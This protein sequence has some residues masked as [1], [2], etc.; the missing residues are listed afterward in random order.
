LSMI[1]SPSAFPLPMP[2]RYSTAANESERQDQSAKRT[3]FPAGFPASFRKIKPLRHHS[4]AGVNHTT[5]C[6]SCK[7]KTDPGNPGRHKGRASAR[8]RPISSSHIPGLEIISQTSRTA[9]CPRFFVTN[10]GQTRIIAYGM[11][12]PARRSTAIDDVISHAGDLFR[13]S[14]D[15]ARISLKTASLSR[16]PGIPFQCRARGRGSPQPGISGPSGRS[17]DPA[18]WISFRPW[19][20]RTLKHLVSCPSSLMMIR[21]SVVHRPRQGSGL[22]P[23][24]LR[25]RSAL[26]SHRVHHRPFFMVRFTSASIP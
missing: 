24:D 3:V 7:A 6:P 4:I 1:F 18:R 23:S 12:T 22:S 21:P 25:I 16:H 20:S 17:L 10:H 11:D 5:R 19:P 13:A 2:P 8:Y 15:E 9:P 26:S 14:P